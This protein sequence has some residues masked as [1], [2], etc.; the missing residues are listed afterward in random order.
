M[1]ETWTLQQDK[2]EA[3]RI[4]SEGDVPASAVLDSVDLY[5]NPHLLARGFIKEVEHEEKGTI[6]LLGWPAKMSESE[7]E[8]TAACP[9]GKYT[10]EVV[11]EDL[12]LSPDELAAL[13]IQGAFG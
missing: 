4:L 10:D 9:L 11:S 7:V 13:K 5:K 8:I 6:R 12:G 2:F 3:M 1:V